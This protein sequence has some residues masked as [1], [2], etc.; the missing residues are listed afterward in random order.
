MRSTRSSFVTLG[1][2]ALLAAVITTMPQSASACGDKNSACAC[3]AAC[4]SQHAEGGA[5]GACACGGAAQA[6]AAADSGAG[7]CQHAAG[8]AAAQRAVIDPA[9]GQ[10]TVPA[11][12]QPLEGDIPPASTRAAS[13]SVEVAQPGGGVMAA[14]PADRAPRA[15]ATI[16]A[17]GAAHTGC[18]E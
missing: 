4:P 18:S 7:G 13:A 5:A 1:S 16:D 9:T 17:D 12:G 8:A 3:G 10:L 14:V 6:A 15:M 2:L 11:D